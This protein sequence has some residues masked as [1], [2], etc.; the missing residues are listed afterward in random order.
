M[1]DL[2]LNPNRSVFTDTDSD[3]DFTVYKKKGSKI[4]FSDTESDNDEDFMQKSV[5]PS[6]PK[7]S[8]S[9]STISSSNS[10][11]SI[12]STSNSKVMSNGKH[13]QLLNTYMMIF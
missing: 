3:D 5:K 11:A 6:I 12:A 13:Q 7:A 2:F 1:I 9:N 8:T 4:I 10:K